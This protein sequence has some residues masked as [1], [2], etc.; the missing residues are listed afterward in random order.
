MSS[1]FKRW[2]LPGF[3]FKAVVIGGGYAT[4]REL[5]EFFLPSGPWGGVFGMLLAMLMWSVI[6]ALT[7]L[8]ARRTQSYDYGSF[9][10]NLLGRGAFLFDVAYFCFILVLLSVFGAAAGAIGTALFGWPPIVGVLALM[11]GIAFFTALGSESVE[12]LFKYVTIF[13]YCVYALFLILALAKFPH[14]VRTGF[15]KPHSID[16]WAVGG[17]TYTGYNIIGA[18]IVLPVLRHLTSNRDAL[19]AGILCGPLAMVP[20]LIFFICM[21]AFYPAISASALP[22]DYLLVRLNVPV[23]HFAFQLMIFAALLESSCGCVHAINER[24]A[25]F[26]AARGHK[27]SPLGRLGLSTLVLVVS[28]FVAARFGFVA[29]IANG[30]RVLSYVFLLIYVVPI[31]TYGA[32]RLFRGRKESFTASVREGDWPA[33]ENHGRVSASP[34]IARSD[35]R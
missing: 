33:S 28:I 22:S 31:M 24:V 34:A 3:A 7:F 16:G 9:F 5:A 18:V 19:V 12:Q 8:F 30:Y 17:V 4:G 32:W 10:R 2:F 14:L 35:A 13:L 27:L 20:A 25:R 15:A 11:I 26:A 29:L 23:F 21:A 6:C 1:I